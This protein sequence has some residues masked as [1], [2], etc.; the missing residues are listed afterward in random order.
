[1]GDAVRIRTMQDRGEFVRGVGQ[2]D[3]LERQDATEQAAVDLGQHDVHGEVGRAEAPRAADPGVACTARLDDLQHGR[4]GRV[5]DGAAAGPL[6][7]KRGGVENDVGRVRLDQA[8]QNRNRGLV[9]EARDRD[10]RDAGAADLQRIG[11]GLPPA[12]CRRPAGPSGRR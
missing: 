1:M 3:I 2:P 6:G 4:V 9:L 11:Q 7:R 8:G 10:R 12:R 5:E